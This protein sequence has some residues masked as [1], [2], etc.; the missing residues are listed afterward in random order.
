MDM[1]LDIKIKVYGLG[2]GG[3][4]AVENMIRHGVEGVDFALANTDLQVLNRSQCEEKNT[5]WEE[6]DDGAW[7]RCQSGYRTK[8]MH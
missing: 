2:G 8:G 6:Y 5:A 1:N 4:N 7:C 3:G